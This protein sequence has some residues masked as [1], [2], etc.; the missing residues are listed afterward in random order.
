[1]YVLCTYIYLSREN[2]FSIKFFY[3]F[4]LNFLY[5]K[6]IWIFFFN[7]CLTMFGELY[8]RWSSHTY[9]GTLLYN[10]DKRSCLIYS[11]IIKMCAGRWKNKIFKKK[12]SQF[13]PILITLKGTRRKWL[14][15]WGTVTDTLGERISKR[16]KWKYSLCCPPGCTAISKKGQFLL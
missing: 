5:E 11:F 3:I 14:F 16:M 4:F 8:E 12:K 15:K 10:S 2:G 1:M 6:K 7:K 9:I 13:F